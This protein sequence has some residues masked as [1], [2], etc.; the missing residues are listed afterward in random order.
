MIAAIIDIN[1]F[2]NNLTVIVL[3]LEK[4]KTEH[5]VTSLVRYT[6]MPIDSVDMPAQ[7][8][9]SSLIIRCKYYSTDKCFFCKLQ[10]KISFGLPVHQYTFECW[11][12][13][14]LKWNGISC[15]M[16]ED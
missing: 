15:C 16:R 3:L 9:I 4:R 14:G 1:S 6:V 10:S 7:R 11:G 2:K 8:S 5:K 13:N 12:R